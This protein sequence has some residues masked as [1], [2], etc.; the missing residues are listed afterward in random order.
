MRLPS[1]MPSG[2]EE[3]VVCPGCELRTE[4]SGQRAV[5]REALGGMNDPAAEVDAECHGPLR[6]LVHVAATQANIVGPA[7][8]AVESLDGVGRSLRIGERYTEL[9]VLEGAV[10][11]LEYRRAG[12]LC[13]QRPAAPENEGEQ[14]DRTR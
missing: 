13:R 12:L 10:R 8:E 6:P 3:G 9:P 2:N 1:E 4:A 7:S 14:H 5:E 11:R